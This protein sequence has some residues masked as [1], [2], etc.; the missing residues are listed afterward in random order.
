MGAALAA[1][2]TALTGEAW[3]LVHYII[4][5]LETNGVFRI[6]ILLYAY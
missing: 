1:V 3:V 4:I 5:F 2:L 6:S